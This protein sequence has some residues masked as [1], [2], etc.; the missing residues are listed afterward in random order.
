MCG[1]GR[2]QGAKEVGLTSSSEVSWN[3]PPPGRIWQSAEKTQLYL[4]R[5]EW[6][7][8]R[9]QLIAAAVK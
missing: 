3:Q 8:R 4:W 6:I 7:T 1:D 2:E 5:R 9:L